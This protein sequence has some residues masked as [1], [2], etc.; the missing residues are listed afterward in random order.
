META[1]AAVMQRQPQ[2]ACIWPQVRFDEAQGFV[3]CDPHGWLTDQDLQTLA[4]DVK[5]MGAAVRIEA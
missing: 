4:Q 1:L 2:P 3:L 5:F